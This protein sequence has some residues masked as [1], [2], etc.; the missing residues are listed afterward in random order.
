[1]ASRNRPNPPTEL[2][3]EIDSV[4]ERAAAWINHNGQLVAGAI[5]A[6]LLV[7]LAL[8]IGSSLRE[9]S[10]QK[11][12]AEVAG[13]LSAYLSAMGASPGAVEAPEPANPELG[14]KTRAE[15]ADKLLAASS[16][17]E[18]TAA[19]TEGRLQAAALLEKNG[20]QEAAFMA[21]KLAAENAPSGSAV[22]AIALARYAVA[23]ESKGDAKAAAAALEEA[24]EIES[25]GQALMLADGAR[26]LADAGE[27]EKAIALYRRAEKLGV[28]ALPPHLKARM[29]GLI[30]EAK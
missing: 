23:L 19:A 21:R 17:H 26:V 8:G 9:R 7:G 5:G 22:R 6:V 16:A 27:R 28:D 29:Q 20:D 14:R 10:A 12:Q 13:V 11:V 2:V 24:A 4:F 30:A 25:P 18:G 3:G 15:F 1:M